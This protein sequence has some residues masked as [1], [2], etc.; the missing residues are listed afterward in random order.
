MLWREAQLTGDWGWIEKL[1][2][3]VIAEVNNIK[4]FREMTRKDSTQANYGLMPM[5]TGDGGLGWLHREYTNVY[6]TLYGLKAALSIAEKLKKP[7]LDD[8]KA[9]YENYHKVFD[10]ARKRDKLLDSKGNEYVPI[11][12]YNDDSLI[13]RTGVGGNLLYP[14]TM[15]KEDPQ[16]PQRGCWTFLQSI[17]PGEIYSPDD[18]LM[19]GT[20]HMLDGTIREGQVLGTGWLAH[21]IWTYHAGMYAEA[22][23]WLGDSKKAVSI[24]YAFANHASP[25]LTWVEEQYPICE[26]LGEEYGGDMPHNWASAELILLVRNLLILEKGKEL[27]LLEGMPDS[28]AEPGKTTDLK[29]I[30]TSFGEADLMV[31]VDADGLMAHVT[32]NLKAREI[33]EKLIIHLESFRKPIWTIKGEDGYLKPEDNVVEF[34]GNQVKLDIKFRHDVEQRYVSPKPGFDYVPNYK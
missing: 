6:G 20:L 31:K 7:E 25:M 12:M 34:N 22:H 8:W 27:H 33:P 9:E 28:W 21:G 1:W 5:G 29:N 16:L 4:K 14:I 32:F 15:K 24:L 23:L 19:L 26:Q 3:K 30:L 18:P 10:K 17:Y 13:P 11:T 2:P